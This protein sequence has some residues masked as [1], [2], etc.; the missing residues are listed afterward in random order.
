M[1]ADGRSRTA[2]R[3]IHYGGPGNCRIIRVALK[4]RVGGFHV[5]RCVAL[6]AY[7][8]RIVKMERARSRFAVVISTP[9]TVIALAAYALAPVW[10]ALLSNAIWQALT[11]IIHAEILG[12]WALTA[13]TTATIRAAFLALAIGN[14]D[15]LPI[16]ALV[17]RAARALGAVGSLRERA[18]RN[19]VARGQNTGGVVRAIQDRAG[20]EYADWNIQSRVANQVTVANIAIVERLTIGIGF[21][22]TS[23]GK[24]FREREQGADAVSAHARVVDGARIPV[25][26]ESTIACVV[27]FPKRIAGIGRAF[28]GIVARS[29]QALGLQTGIATLLVFAQ[30]CTI[31]SA[32]GSV[33]RRLA[34][35]SISAGATQAFAAVVAASLVLTVRHTLAYSFDTGEFDST[36]FHA[37]PANAAAA[38]RTALLAEAAG[39]A[40][41][42]VSI[43]TAIR[44]LL[45][46]FLLFIAGV[47]PADIASVFAAVC[48]V[49]V[50]AEALAVDANHVLRAQTA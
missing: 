15:A 35:V 44:A 3:A 46:D 45:P 47:V 13:R 5:R 33:P 9:E 49:L 43:L 36:G 7:F 48:V 22:C 23:I 19:G 27:A 38:I 1:K 17:L 34:D 21:A 4:A 11:L 18:A 28:V 41:Q 39:L 25:V 10:A 16:K 40:F 32:Q 6:S 26:T 8:A 20:I 24:R 14:A 31:G 2:R 29:A 50:D 30:G 12:S 42:A 37:I